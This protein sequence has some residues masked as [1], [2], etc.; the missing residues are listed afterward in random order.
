MPN[1]GSDALQQ[2]SSRKYRPDDRPRLMVMPPRDWRR[3]RELYRRCRPAR[4]RTTSSA[5]S[6]PAR[7]AR[8]VGDREELRRRARIARVLSRWENAAAPAHLLP[9]S[10]RWRARRAESP[11]AR[12]LRW[13][14]CHSSMVNSGACAAPRTHDCRKTQAKSKMRVSPG[15]ATSA[16]LNREVGGEVAGDTSVRRVPSVPTRSVA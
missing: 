5:E 4:L 9:P 11:P 16:W 1:R 3:R 13:R 15:V 7:C 8:G 14:D 10:R 6:M 12:G 2:V